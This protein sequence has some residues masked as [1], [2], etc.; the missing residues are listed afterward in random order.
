MNRKVAIMLLALPLGALSVMARSA[1]AAE[2][3]FATANQ[4]APLVVA[5]LN[6]QYDQRDDHQTRTQQT[7]ARREAERQAQVRREAEQQ[8]QARRNAERQ[9][10]AH[11]NTS[12]RV[13]V[14]G[15]YEGGFLGIGRKWV[16]GHWTQS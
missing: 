3:N 10:Q 13:W 9:A 12:H 6:N 1:T 2:T 5:Q 8:A 4:P 14:A 15:H 11:R 7:Q 16:P